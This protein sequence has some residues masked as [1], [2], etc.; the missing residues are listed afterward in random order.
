MYFIV[1]IIFLDSFSSYYECVGWKLEHPGTRHT[2]T[3]LQSV[4]G[5]GGY[6]EQRT[7][8]YI[9]QYSSSL[10]RA[11]EV[12]TTDNRSHPIAIVHCDSITRIIYATDKINFTL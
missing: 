9:S 10:V 11:Q 7:V 3:W 12:I 4:Q 6:K 5:L 8:L 1:N 2:N